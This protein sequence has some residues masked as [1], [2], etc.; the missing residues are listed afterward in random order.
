MIY[1]FIDRTSWST[2]ANFSQMYTQVYEQMVEVKIAAEVPILV[3]MDNNFTEVLEED[4]TGCKVT[5]DLE[6]P[7]MYKVMDEVGGNISQKE[8]GNKGGKYKR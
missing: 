4:A 6:H 8:Y 1:L 5:H 2:F 7:E 3:W